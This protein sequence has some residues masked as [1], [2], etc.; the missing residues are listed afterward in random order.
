[1]P[2]SPTG[3]SGTRSA[4]SIGSDVLVFVDGLILC[5]DESLTGEDE[6]ESRGR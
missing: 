1:M 3:S 5:G 2:R 6:H 4:L